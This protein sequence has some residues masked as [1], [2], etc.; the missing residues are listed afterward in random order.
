MNDSGAKKVAILVAGMHRSGTSALTRVLNLAGC[1]LPKTLVRPRRGNLAGFWESQP[2]VNLNMEILASAESFWDDLRRFDR[3]WCSSSVA[4]GFRERAQQILQEEFGSSSLFVL[5]DPRTCRLMEFWIEAVKAFGARPLVVSPIRNPLDVAASL[6]VRDRIRPSVGHLIW[7]RHALDAEADSRGLKRAYLRYERLLTDPQT[8]V[9]TLGN[10]LGV[11]WPGRSGPHAEVKIAEFLSAELRHHESEDALALSNPDLLDW[12]R[13]SFEIFDRWARGEVREEDAVDL[14]RIKAAFDEVTQAFSYPRVAVQRERKRVRV[15]SNEL[16]SSRRLVADH[17]SRIEILSSQ[18]AASRREAVNYKVRIEALSS[19]TETFHQGEAN[20]KR[21]D[22]EG[23]GPGSDLQADCESTAF[24]TLDADL[25]D[26]VHSCSGTVKRVCIATSDMPG[27]DESSGIGTALFHL[28]RLLAERGHDV[29]IACVNRNALN[30]RLMEDA[31]IL[32][33]GIGVVLEPVVPRS[34]PSMKPLARVSAPTWALFEWL[35]CREPCFDFVHVSGSHGLG[36][37]P[38][39]AKSQG[40]AFGATHFVVHGHGPTLWK[41]E[42]SRQ[43]VATNRELGWVFMERRC[44]ELADTVICGSVHLLEWMRDAGYALP[45][46]SF[47]LPGPFPVA[48]ASVTERAA[49]DVVRLEEVVFFGRLEP[50]KGLVLFVDAID[51]L[52]RRGRAPACITFLGGRSDRFDGPGLVRSA[53]RRWPGEVRTITDFGSREAVAYLS[54]PGRLAV[55]PSLLDSSSMA[56]MEC[57]HAGIPF[58]AAA[59]GGTPELVA[60]E[61]HARALV[62]PDHIALGERIAAFGSAPLRAAHPRREFKHLF[63]VWSRWHAQAAPFEAAAA[64]FA[65]RAQFSGAETPLVTVCIVH[66]ERPALVRMAVDSVLDQDYPALEAVLV[67]DGS[68]SAEALTTL[69]ALEARFAERGWRVVR[70]ENRYLGAARNAAVAAARGEW[71]LF[72]DDDNILFPDAVS[73]LVRAARFSGADCVPAA[74]IRFFGDGDPRTDTGSH[75]APFRYLGAARAWSH[76]RNV[77]GDACALVRREVFEA[78]GGFTEEYRV[79]LDD[80]SLFNRLIMTGHRVEPNPDPAY[81]YR[82]GRTS[83]KSRNRSAEAAQVRVLTPHL[84]GLPDEERA[85]GAYAAARMRALT[86][87]EDHFRSWAEAAM[88]REEWTEA[89]ERWGELRLAFPDGASGYVR[90][91]AALLGAGRLD[92]A[93]ALACEAVKRFP[94]RPEG[95]YHRAEVAMVRKDWTEASDRWAELCQEFPE[96]PSGY[97][98][99]AEA[100]RNAG[101]LDEAERLASEAVSRF[102]DGPRGYVQ[103]AEI[104]MVREDWASASDRWGELRQAF[105]DDSSGYVRGAAALMNAGRLDEAEGLACEAMKRF[106]DRPGG[107]VQWAEVAMRRG[108]WALASERWGELRRAFPHHTSGYM[109]GAAA[110]RNAGHLDEAE[111]LACEAMKRFPDRPG[112][113]I[114]WAGVAMRRGDW[115]LASERW[116]ELRR[117]FPHH[118][119]GY[120]RGAATLRNAGHLDEAEGLAC[121]AIK[122]FPDRSGGRVQWAEVAMRRGDWA[123]ASERWSELRLAFPDD[124]SGYVRG[125][126]ALRNAGHPDKAEALEREAASSFPGTHSRGSGRVGRDGS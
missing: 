71:L 33:A 88:R 30:F 83:M 107:W 105:P 112:G 12:A 11:S 51:R 92:E 23:S 25:G 80:L 86:E 36:Y 118:T 3:N 18:L 32:C 111:G 79:G 17:S 56:V 29:V 69:D 54:H 67:D 9:D 61:D 116:G 6:Q 103:R 43:L 46:R 113:W 58:V 96:D 52:A 78:V 55:I 53:A 13:A 94:D 97:V 108:D 38:L 16:D 65:R 84:H 59:T 40:I 119:A 99:G 102:P 19:G 31:R 22:R 57:L 75:G 8:V 44:I 49:R 4:D 64:H 47:V 70:Q 72:L 7:L 124:P 74:S 98:R 1:D 63:D 123:L 104:A 85:Y 14:G 27:P 121:E 93:A 5:K 81:Y 68:E 110:L 87:S 2:I 20:R 120:M 48:P 24:S 39:L 122:Q 26:G 95:H 89:S 37:G 66:H 82:I 100:L 117:A 60:P 76:F 50:R 10:D 41:L 109:R 115:T 73:R 90:G 106:P 21:T 42:G 35:R 126:A 77:V 28:A 34:S 125:A 91:A 15:L 45:G 62:A 101:C 114:Q